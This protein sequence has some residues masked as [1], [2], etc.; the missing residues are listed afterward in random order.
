MKA[1][2]LVSTETLAAHLDDPEWIVFD[3]R[4][5]L[6]W[7]EKGREA[8]KAAHVPGA[9]FMHMDEDLSGSKTGKNGRHPLPAIADFAAR[10]NRCGVAPGRQVVVY[11]D[12][13]GSFAVRLWWML[14]WLGHERVALLDGGF[15]AW[16]RESRPLDAAV[17][18]PR[19]GRFEPR[20]AQGATVDTAAV[21]AG[22]GG[23]GMVILD[24]RAAT[25]YMGE[26]ET[27]DPVAG[28]IP[29][30]LNR[31][32]QHN[33]GYD[34]R[35]LPPE[36]LHAEFIEEL[37]EVPPSSVVHSCGSGVT[38]CHNLFAMELAGLAGSRLYPGSWSEWCA[39]PS[40]PVATGPK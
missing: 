34:G 9:F 19:D 18:A 3:T 25:R 15:A 22:L 14:R 17:P 12:G 27:L 4:H 26:N 10:M 2:L 13:G 5:D 1:E 38:A 20:P 28:H 40:R 37:G 24:A 29:G 36:E 7:P 39:D 21:A 30:S 23:P 16:K 6:A 33:L 31:F 32:W 8:W 35:F 11:D